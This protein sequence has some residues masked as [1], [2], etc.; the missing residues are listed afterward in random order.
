MEAMRLLE[1]DSTLLRQEQLQE[2]QQW[3]RTHMLRR[4]LETIAVL[5]FGG[6]FLSCHP[7]ILMLI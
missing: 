7:T 2:L 3:E 5:E 1:G 6:K 4:T